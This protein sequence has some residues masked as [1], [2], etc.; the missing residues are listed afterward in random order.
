M[1]GSLHKLVLVA[2]CVLLHRRKPGLHSERKICL[3]VRLGRT[4]IKKKLKIKIYIYIYICIYS[5]PVLKQYILAGPPF[6]IFQEIPS[7]VNSNRVAQTPS[8]GGSSGNFRSTQLFAPGERERY[9]N[10]FEN[11]GPTNGLLDG[12]KARNVFLLAQLSNETLGRIW[13]LADTK[14]RGALDSSEF[15]IAMYFIQALMKGTLNSVPDVLPP[16]IYEEAY[17]SSTI[18]PISPT[19]STGSA[20]LRRQETMPNFSHPVSPIREQLTGKSSVLGSSSV[21]AGGSDGNWDVKPADMR[22]YEAY[23][24]NIDKNKKGY[25]TGDEAVPFLMNSKVSEDTL[26]HIWDLSDIQKQG[27]LSKEEFAVAMY[28]IRQKLTGG[29]LPEVLPQS[30]VPPSLRSLEINFAAFATPSV[31]TPVSSQPTGSA[32]DLFGLNDSFVTPAGT[33]EQPPLAFTSYARS[34]KSEFVPPPTM[35]AATFSPLSSSELSSPHIKPFVPTS[36]FG[37]SIKT[38]NLGASTSSI[39]DQK[40]QVQDFPPPFA[41]TDLLGDTD[42]EISKK[43]TSET[44]E[45]AN[46]SNQISSLNKG[47]QELKLER[48]TAEKNLEDTSS[49]KKAIESKL[50]QLQVLYEGEVNSVKRVKEM[51][52][53]SKDETAKMRQELSVLEASYHALQQHHQDLS[54]SLQQDQQEN[55][56]LKQRIQVVNEESASLKENL[57]KVKRD[58][59]QQ[60]GLVSINKKQLLTLEGQRET[61]RSEIESENVNLNAL[62]EETASLQK[63]YEEREA[64]AS[65]NAI[66][67]TQFN[68][69][70]LQIN[71]TQGSQHSQNFFQT[72]NP[73]FTQHFQ[74]F[75]PVVQQNREGGQSSLSDETPEPIKNAIGSVSQGNHNYGN[76][77]Y[78]AEI[79]TEMLVPPPVSAFSDSVMSTPVDTSHSIPIESANQDSTKEKEVAVVDERKAEVEEEEEE[80]VDEIQDLH[81]L[82]SA[83]LAARDKGYVLHSPVDE[84]GDVKQ[85]S[86]SEIQTE[87]T[88]S[89]IQENLG[90]FS[91]EPADNQSSIV[92]DML[93]SQAAS[94]QEPVDIEPLESRSAE[95]SL[96][97]PSEPSYLFSE[98]K[99]PVESPLD[100]SQSGPNFLSQFGHS[101]NPFHVYRQEDINTPGTEFS[102]A[103]ISSTVAEINSVPDIPSTATQTN[104]SQLPPIAQTSIEEKLSIPGTFP[105]ADVAS[106]WN[107]SPTAEAISAGAQSEI[108]MDTTK[109]HPDATSTSRE[110]PLS[111]QAG[112]DEKTDNAAEPIKSLDSGT[113]AEQEFSSFEPVAPVPTKAIQTPFDDAFNDLEEA[114]ADPDQSFDNSF[115]SNNGFHEFDPSF[116]N[117]FEQ[118][119][120]IAAASTSNNLPPL[121]FESAFAS[122][123]N[124]SIPAQDSSSPVKDVTSAATEM[125]SQWNKPVA[126]DDPSL[127]HLLGMGFPRDK[128]LKALEKH[129]FNLEEVLN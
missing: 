111:F 109:A 112:V 102:S 46:L 103:E 27:R 76:E 124:P 59:R 67:N 20:Q 101:T 108:H 80:R 66:H 95:A 51:L 70:H 3:N 119:A 38:P 44:A 28:L 19:L 42:P 117:H 127:E 94:D 93:H 30:L 110:D 8:L 33:G 1:K 96:D 68:Q 10:M 77:I 2:Q 29:I 72:Q 63:Q 118:N 57:E 52:L 12:E 22:Q 25:I 85:T 126:H 4:Q 21:G 14:Q 37:Q 9:I 47:T 121:D 115:F 87:H 129:N 56:T 99:T 120:P 78:E 13:S 50:V 7:A 92:K 81:P 18:S 104:K 35:R 65:S 107:S 89:E 71:E 100:A 60:K 97:N 116:D 62:R 122:F 125:A 73:L 91:E 128:A 88:F 74:D 86:S 11:T 5:R 40:P 113:L 49:Q 69:P 64:Q 6:P 54:F 39:V 16:G 45:L 61:V 90:A 82:S 36:Q 114:Q 31:P 34:D 23:F 15:A 58:A 106:A 41:S 24:R 75:E 84:V 17:R 53:K 83:A 98:N 105:G 55:V 79:P 123:D 48:S 26:A 32:A 43:L